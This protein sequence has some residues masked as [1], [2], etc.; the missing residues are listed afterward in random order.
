MTILKR[1]I[2]AITFNV[3]IS[4]SFFSILAISNNVELPSKTAWW[5]IA[6]LSGMK[7]VEIAKP[8]I[9][10]SFNGGGRTDE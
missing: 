4:I 8:Y 7:A 2:H 9:E 5:L 3:Y 10:S 6:I 1:I